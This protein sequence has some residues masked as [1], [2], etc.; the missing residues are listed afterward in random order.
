MSHMHAAVQSL[1]TA[2]ELSALSR[3]L[4]SKMPDEAFLD[5]LP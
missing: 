4:F 5:E 2:E 1:G 3:V